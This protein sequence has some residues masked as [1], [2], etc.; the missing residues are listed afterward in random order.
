MAGWDRFSLFALDGSTAYGERVARR[1]EQPLAAHEERVFED[2]EGKIRP[3]AA[4]HGHHAFVIHSLHADGGQST[5]GQSTGG[6]SSNRQSTHDK[7]CRLLFFIAALRDAGAARVTAVTPYLCYA[8]KDRRTQPQDPVTSRYVAQLFEA[9]GTD[10]LMTI[11][12]HNQA[13]FQNAFRCVTDHLEAAPLFLEHFAPLLRGQ[14]A[15][16]LSPDIGGVKR[17]EEFRRALAARLGAEP[18]AAFVEKRRARGVVSGEQ[19]VGEVAGRIVV[20]L[21]DMIST[22][23]T[24][25]R[26]AAAA[27]AA[28]AARIF[29]A[30][31][32]GLFQGDPARLLGDPA[33]DGIVVADTVPPP[34]L[35]PELA[36]RLAVL[37]SSSLVAEAIIAHRGGV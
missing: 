3:L 35:P 5:S 22:G 34:D 20:M 25:R 32:H 36:A 15:A 23:G 12:V 1:L 16:V 19:L 28:G 30:A 24:L 4:L 37:D 9:V 27:R 8:R 7:L 29:A 18:T 26:A 13:A 11:D 21:D 33:L 31:T 14:P 6:Q 2:G 10:A 17:A